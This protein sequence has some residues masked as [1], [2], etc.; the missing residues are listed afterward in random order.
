MCA[1]SGSALL[2]SGLP[3]P[4]AVRRII[5]D[6]FRYWGLGCQKLRRCAIRI[7]V[8]SDI[9]PW[10]PTGGSKRIGVTCSALAEIGSVDLLLLPVPS[11]VPKANPERPAGFSAD[12]HEPAVNAGMLGAVF[13]IAGPRPA[14]AGQ[15]HES[16]ETEIAS[17]RRSVSAE[18]ARYLSGRTYDLAWFNRERAWLLAAEHVTAPCIIDVDDFEDILIERWL[19]LGKDEH[20]RP[21][22]KQSR[23]RMVSDIAWWRR[24]HD[25][26]AGQA[27]TLV[28]SSKLDQERAGYLNSVTIPNV[29]RLDPGDSSPGEMDVCSRPTVLFQG[30]LRWP[31]NEDAAQWLVNEIFPLIRD[32]VPGARI[33]LVGESSPSVR[34]LA[35]NDGVEITGE[36]PRMQPYLRRAHVV[37][38]PLRVGGGT[39]IK[40]LEAFAHHVPVVSTRI[41]TEGL[42]VTAGVHLE[43]A[44][45]AQGIAES[46]ANLLLS[47]RRRAELADAAYE[48]YDSH[49]RPEHAR[50]CILRAVRDVLQMRH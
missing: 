32:R 16:I 8:I 35:V 26:A 48:L 12:E 25:S 24:V 46:C 30:W 41:G 49:Y 19:N 47:P 17:T 42:E 9:A 13:N 21:V 37:T 11:T 14:G 1:R 7:L 4:C 45:D 15:S 38:V 44:D 43:Q 39:R 10:G 40:I 27:R 2:S 23:T 22:T 28:F 31:P 20:G 6:P 50:Q 33:I 29:Y 3:I 34:A 5:I 36:V 18:I